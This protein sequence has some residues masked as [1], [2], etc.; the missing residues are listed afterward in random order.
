MA[1][2]TAFSRACGLPVIVDAAAAFDAVRSAPLPTVVSLHATK[3]LRLSVPGMRELSAQFRQLA[4]DSGGSYDGWS[5]GLV[6]RTED[7]H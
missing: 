6:S 4:K 2:W 3:A 1:A 5:A 7:P